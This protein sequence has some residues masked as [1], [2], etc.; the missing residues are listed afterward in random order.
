LRLVLVIP[1]A[2]EH[3]LPPL[4][5]KFRET[6]RAELSTW[7]LRQE[8]IVVINAERARRIGLIRDTKA[9]GGGGSAPWA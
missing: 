1:T 8:N 7:S 4:T 3:A 5:E 6:L 2:P 9:P